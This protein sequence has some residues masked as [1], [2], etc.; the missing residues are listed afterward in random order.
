[1]L[2]GQRLKPGLRMGERPPQHDDAMSAVRSPKPTASGLLAQWVSR[3]AILPMIAA[4]S[5]PTGAG[6][7]DL[8]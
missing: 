5:Q 2:T 8:Q 3:N 7:M 6:A 1:M 4:L